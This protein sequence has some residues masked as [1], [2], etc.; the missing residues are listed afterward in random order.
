MRPN[1]SFQLHVFK[2]T[3]FVRDENQV[4]VLD[5]AP[6][7]G[8]VRFRLYQLERERRYKNSVQTMAERTW[9]STIFYPSTLDDTYLWIGPFSGRLNRMHKRNR[10]NYPFTD[11][12]GLASNVYLP[13][14]PATTGNCG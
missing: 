12:Q 14:F 1:S 13:S 9:D 3:A 6:G 11:A 8:L 7:D 10:G 4:L 5:S 2:P